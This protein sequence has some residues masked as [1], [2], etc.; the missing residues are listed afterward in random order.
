MFNFSL[1]SNPSKARIKID[2]ENDEVYWFEKLREILTC[3]NPR[4]RYQKWSKS[5]IPAISFTGMYNTG[6]TYEILRTLRK[7]N[8]AIVCNISKSLQQQIQPFSVNSVIKVPKNPTYTYRDYQLEAIR[9]GMKRG[10]G[11]VLLP[12]SAGKSLII[13]GLLN[14]MDLTDKNV[15]ILVPNINLVKQFYEDMKDYGDDVSRIQMFSGFNGVLEPDK[16][17]IISNRQ[18]LERHHGELPPID[19]VIVDEVHQCLIYNKISKFIRNIPTPIKFGFTGTLP[20]SV[21]EKWN[22]IG[23]FG[24]ILYTEKITTLQ[25][26]K[27]IAN[28]NIYAVKFVHPKTSVDYMQSVYDKFRDDY[29]AII[30]QAELIS[31]GKVKPEDKL[32]FLAGNRAMLEEWKFT[33]SQEPVN[34]KIVELVQRFPGNTLI[35]T[36]HIEH[37]KNLYAMLT[38]PNKHLII[39]ETELDL[40]EAMRTIMET[41]TGN[42]AVCSAKF[43]G[44]GM[45]IKNIQNIVLA[46]S[47]KATTKIIQGIGRGL[48]I[49]E[50]KTCLNLVDLHHNF[51]YSE[52]HF[53]VRCKLYIKWY[54]KN[55]KKISSIQ[56]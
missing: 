36:D 23:I 32:P 44:T 42:I 31:Q 49:K 39:G 11:I 22:I 13:S 14:N 9:Q 5:T 50:G 15:L 2:N 43:V 52:K 29:V 8:P 48:R 30:E 45:N 17:I 56:L 7:L 10:R 4:A 25:E 1:T 35:F 18:W 24:D 38:S 40:R 28:I 53:N 26:Q 12:T 47:G 21:H 16:N 41:S 3:K 55:I 19:V 20:D 27:Y 37:S 51:K 46:C 34:Q 33:E 6:F 54:N